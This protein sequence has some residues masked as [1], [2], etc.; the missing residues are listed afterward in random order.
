MLPVS[1]N[2]LAYPQT[3]SPI[4]QPHRLAWSATN[5]H[6]AEDGVKSSEARET[7]ASAMSKLLPHG[8]LSNGKR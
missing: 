6:I 4:S 3:L 8:K 7:K 5:D 1:S 2:A